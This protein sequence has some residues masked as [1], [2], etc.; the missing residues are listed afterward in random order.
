MEKIFNEIKQP[1]K[2]EKDLKHLLKRFRSLEDDLKI[3]INTEL[4]QYHKLNINIS[5]IFP[6]HSL[7]FDKP[8]AYKATK[9]ACKSLK[10]RGARSGIRITYVYYEEEDIIEFAEMY[11][12]GDKENEDKNRLKC[13]K[14]NI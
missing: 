11:F 2:F 6:I 10:G 1:P 5:G 9:F 14:E 12:K 13:Y 3:F 4:K 8:K 7:G